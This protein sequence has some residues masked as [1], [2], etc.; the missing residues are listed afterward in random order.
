MFQNLPLVRFL[1]VSHQFLMGSLDFLNIFPSETFYCASAGSAW[2]K[3]TLPPLVRTTRRPS[4]RCRHPK[5][6]GILSW[7]DAVRVAPKTRDVQQPPMV[8]LSG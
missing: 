7:K 8:G 1:E 2:E 4:R 5:S 6:I 3:R